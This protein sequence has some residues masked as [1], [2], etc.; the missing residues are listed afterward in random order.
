MGARSL[1]SLSRTGQAGT[2]LVSS[3]ARLERRDF[4][5]VEEATDSTSQPD[6]ASRTVANA[7]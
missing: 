6:T 5:M 1:K 3:A 4:A 2:L 7:F